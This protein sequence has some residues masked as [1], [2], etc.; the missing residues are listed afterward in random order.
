MENRFG[1]GRL[2][3]PTSPGGAGSLGLSSAAAKSRCRS[4]SRCMAHLPG[5]CGKHCRLGTFCLSLE[6][7]P[8]RNV[9]VPLDQRRNRAD[10]AHRMRKEAPDDLVDRA[11]MR[12]DQKR[13]SVVI[14]F[15]CIARKMNLLDV[16]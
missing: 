13:L 16:C 15:P 1:L 4:A 7:R 14:G 9:G 8:G 5:P 2:S 11:I 12:I 3:G 10:E 6:R